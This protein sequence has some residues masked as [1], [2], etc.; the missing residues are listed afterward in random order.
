MAV[1]GRVFG[2]VRGAGMRYRFN[3]CIRLCTGGGEHGCVELLQHSSAWARGLQFGTPAVAG[4]HQKVARKPWNRIHFREDDKTLS[5]M[6]LRPLLPD[7]TRIGN[8]VNHW[9]QWTACAYVLNGIQRIFRWPAVR[10]SFIT[11][12]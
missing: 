4:E 7:V 2:S 8:S 9:K 3:P 12:S 6:S 11:N 1:V 10:A 5:R